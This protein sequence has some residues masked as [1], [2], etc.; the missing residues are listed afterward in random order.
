VDLDNYCPARKG[1]HILLIINHLYLFLFDKN[2]LTHA[3]APAKSKKFL[4]LSYSFCWILHNPFNLHFDHI[5]QFR[6]AISPVT[7]FLIIFN[8]D[9]F[10]RTTIEANFL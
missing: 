3:N 10:S 1:D 5:F 2:N 8:P 6:K 9:I 4:Y 7:F